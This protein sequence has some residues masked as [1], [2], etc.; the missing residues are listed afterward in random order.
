MLIARIRELEQRYIW[1][2]DYSGE[3][4]WVRGSVHVIR[5]LILLIHDFLDGDLNLRAMSLVY[6]TLLS[7]VPLLALSFS[8]LKGFGVHNRL[9]GTLQSYLAPLGEEKGAQIAENIIGF[10]DNMNVRVLGAVGLAFLLY[11]VI[12]LM[13]KIEG[14]FNDVWRVEQQRSFGERFTTF[15][16]VLTIG[17]LLVFSALALTGSVMNTAAMSYLQ[18]IQLV[19]ALIKMLAHLAPFIFIIAAFTFLYAFIPNTRVSIGAAFAGGLVAGVLW[20]LLSFA[21]AYFASGASKYQAIYA[22]FASVIFFLIWL[23]MNWLILLVGASVAF[24]RQHPEVVYMGRRKIY[25]SPAFTEQLAL[26]ILHKVGKR[27]YAAQPGYTLRGLVE[28]YRMPSF[29]IE[30]VLVV[31]AGIG[32]LTRTG[33]DPTMY[34]PNVPF[35]STTVA[36]VVLAIADYQ[37]ENTYQPELPPEPAIAELHQQLAQGRQAVVDQLSLKDLARSLEFDAVVGFEQASET[38]AS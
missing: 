1:E 4:F 7:L 14:A 36:E 5:T 2:R 13:Q 19:G 20:E 25:L 27:F 24:Y 11:T 9:E 10:V 17:P 18:S 22:T 37:P 16:S 21:F 6:T 33:D 35:E 15:I 34:V 3:P 28:A 38:P 23:Y 26:S 12:S 30:H 29:A 8:I 32:I 31:L